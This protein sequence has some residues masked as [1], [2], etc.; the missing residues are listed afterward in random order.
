MPNGSQLREI[1]MN[2][3]ATPIDLVRPPLIAFGAGT[4]ARL[5]QWAR[6]QGYERPF[7]LASSFHAKRLEVLGLGEVAA[8]TDVV[9]EPDVPNF[10]AALAAAQRHR[11]DLVIGFGGGSVMDVAKLVAALLGG[12]QALADV[13]GP[14]KVAG[15][16]VGLAQVA[17]TAGTGSEV[18]TRALVTDP[19]SR[20]K[21]AVQSRHLLAD[22][23][24]VD[25]A[26][27]VTVPP[28]VTAETG[29]DAM[30]H[31]VEAF[32]NIKAHPI[33]DAYAIEGTRLVGRYLARAVAD[34]GDLEARGG[35][36]LASL[37]GGICLGPV[38]TAGG[39]AIAYPL[40]TRHHIP[41]G[42]ANAV[43]FPH[44][45]AYNAPAVPAKTALVLEALGLP[46]SDDPATVLAHTSG[47][48]ARLGI[49]MRMGPRGVPESD[50]PAMAEE[51]FAI[52]RLIDNN[53]RP[54]SSEAI[55]AMY[56]AAF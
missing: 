24:I 12:E 32:T 40:G 26:L 52:K 45:L 2:T 10:E 48:C 11:P 14:D 37:Y 5:A 7:V 25:P 8:F 47:F 42:A 36:A 6:E 9:A 23:A 53:P 41:H 56:R 54:L 38:N 50:L 29:I 15:R 31:C 33:I 19:V 22:I 3:F 34:G 20:N 46:A 30:A 55:L 39:H 43:I 28:Q 17:T 21:W 16:S 1:P 4:V 49:E 27:M 35:M 51:A 13:V 18:G 44:V